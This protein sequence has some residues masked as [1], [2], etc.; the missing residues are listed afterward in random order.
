MKP[1]QPDDR[2]ATSNAASFEGQADLPPPGI[3]REFGDFLLHNKKWW[4]LPIVVVLLLVALLVFV[5]AS[6]AGPLIYT[7]F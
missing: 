4:L 1:R 6:G 3:V 7:L 2:P 5:G